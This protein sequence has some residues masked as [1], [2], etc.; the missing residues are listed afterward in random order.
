MPQTRT[1]LIAGQQRHLH[2][3][4]P[5]RYDPRDHKFELHVRPIRKPPQ[6]EVNPSV[7]SIVFDQGDLGSC[8]ANGNVMLW[9]TVRRILGNPEVEMSRLWL[10][11]K[12]RDLEGTPL[13]EDSGMQVRDALKVM[14]SLGLPHEELWP[15][16]I[17][18]FNVEPPAEA[19]AD[20]A[21]HKILVYRACPSP[22]AIKQ[23]IIEGFPVVFGTTLYDSFESDETAQTGIIKAPGP[24][25][26]VVGGHCMVIIGY[27]DQRR[28]FHL[29][30][31]YGTGWGEEGDGWL[32]YWYFQSG[33]AGDA[34]TVRQEQ[35]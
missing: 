9:E 27:D 21:Q 3:Y 11:A 34:W 32:D 28:L 25:E 23:S 35:V 31:S 7:L 19:D 14:A 12:G 17:S 20:A 13:D 4:R 6:A 15:Y 33:A 29:R 16:D 22:D 5:G 10:Y 1:R 2:G 26:A 30:N 8:V 18:K 24:T